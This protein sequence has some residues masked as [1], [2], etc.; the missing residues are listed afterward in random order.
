MISI[1]ETSPRPDRGKREIC[2]RFPNTKTVRWPTYFR[3]KFPNLGLG[4]SNMRRGMKTIFMHLRTPSWPRH[5]CSRELALPLTKFMP[6]RAITLTSLLC[7]TFAIWLNS[8]KFDRVIAFN[9]I[10]E[11]VCFRTFLIENWSERRIWLSEEDQCMLVSSLEPR[12]SF[13]PH[14]RFSLTSCEHKI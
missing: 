13:F 6:R 12:M 3:F 5:I 8:P 10:A 14:L 11:W 7:F 1:R 2:C 9:P 4:N